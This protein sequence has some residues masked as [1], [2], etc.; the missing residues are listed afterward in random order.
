MQK[1]ILIIAGIII[2]ALIVVFALIPKHSAETNDKPIIK[3]GIIL[4]LTGESAEVGQSAKAGLS[5]TLSD[6]LKS[7]AGTRYDYKLVFEDSKSTARGTAM[8]AKKLISMDHVKALFSLWEI[9]GAIATDIADKNNIISMSVSFGEAVLQGKYAFNTMASYSTQSKE[10]VKELKRRGVK[11]VALF[12]DNSEMREQYEA[13]EKEIKSN[14]NIKIVFKEYFNTG[15]KDYK[16]AIIKAAALKPEMYLISGYPPS[17]YVFLKQL[18]ELTGRNDNVTCIDIFV[19][20]N[21]QDRVIANGLW[22]VDGNSLGTP[23]FQQKL[24]DYADIETQSCTGNIVV[25]LQVLVAAFE[26]APL[27]P[28]ET[29]PNNDNIKRWILNNVKNFKTYAGNVTITDK[30]LIEMENSIKIIKDGKPTAM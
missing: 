5:M 10:M 21:S 17:P 23:E 7:S 29:V 22:Y 3:F 14:S 20:I 30:G 12:I 19:D 1:K 26:N 25:N 28:G 2:I 16:S 11:S 27:E 8:A 9:E 13:L 18:K 6:I 4:P 24:F 15:E